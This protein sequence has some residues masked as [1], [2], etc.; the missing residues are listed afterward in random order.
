MIAAALA[1]NLLAGA[2]LALFLRVRPFDFRV[3]A[4]DFAVLV[5]FNALVWILVSG[6]RVRF[7]GELDSWA[8]LV[9]LAAV[10]LV[11]AAALV[12]A[13]V[14]DQVRGGSG[15]AGWIAILQLAA[16]RLDREQSRFVNDNVGR[17]G[18]EVGEW[19]AAHEPPDT[20]IA[21]NTAGSVPKAGTSTNP[22]A[23][24]APAGPRTCTEGGSPSGSVSG[25]SGMTGSGE[26][27][28]GRQPAIVITRI[29]RIRSRCT[30]GESGVSARGAAL[31]FGCVSWS[32]TSGLLTNQTLY[33]VSYHA[34][35]RG[36]GGG[37]SSP[38]APPGHRQVPAR[39]FRSSSTRRSPTYRFRRYSPPT[40]YSAWLI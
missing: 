32:R 27:T 18:R 8:L 14:L 26:P 30:A 2:R 37:H 17:N 9:Y 39:C 23:K 7:A 4:P 11:L 28:S 29:V 19:L 24:Y 31:G 1:R 16:T 12:V 6:A 38:S 22:E 5:A 3:S 10:P 20:L 36:G 25:G 33:P 40:A 35:K 13:A 34:C 21:T 15:V